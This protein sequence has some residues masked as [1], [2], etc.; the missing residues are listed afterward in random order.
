MRSLIH[1]VRCT[2]G[3]SYSKLSP[4]II[5]E[6]NTACISQLKESCIKGDRTKHIS[7]KFFFTQNLQKDGEI[8]S[9]Q[10]RSNGNLADML[11]M[12]LPAATLEKL[13]FGIELP[14]LRDIN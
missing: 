10:I 12:L 4:T 7:P 1:H 11:T 6:D 5:Y 9:H 13:T 14:R 8:D 3:L 2:C